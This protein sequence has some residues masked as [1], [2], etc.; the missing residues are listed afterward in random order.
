MSASPERARPMWSLFV[1]GA[2]GAA[3]ALVGLTLLTG[4]R[5]DDAQA[6]P[7][8]ALDARP[9]PPDDPA[10]RAW[11]EAAL[12]RAGV[13]AS[14]RRA[15]RFPLRGAGRAPNETFPLLSFGCPDTAPCGPL[16]DALAPELAGAGLALTRSIGGDRPGR[17]LYRAVSAAG[18]PLLALRAFPP[19]P[20]LVVIVSGLGQDAR[21]ADALLRLDEHVTLALRAD[22]PAGT[23]L[24]A[25]L[26]AR[27]REVL[28]ELPLAADATAPHALSAQ[29]TP[30]AL[31][32]QTEALLDRLPGAVG[33]TL[34][35]DDRLLASAAH[36]GAVLQPVGGRGLFVVDA[37]ASPTSVSEATA[38]VLGVRRVGRTHTL[39]ASTSLKA[40]EA[41]LALDGQ[42]TVV[43]PADAAG[44]D[45][46]GAWLGELALRGVRPYRASETAL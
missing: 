25:R 19:G 29:R 21:A 9:P 18:A 2:V 43:V 12:S 32:S 44:L 38:V 30:E 4:P 39:D 14:G 16:L 27:G 41:A 37:P 13:L 46:L 34:T 28:V 10:A 26:A 36:I 40:V 24:A 20:R 3:A 22:A 45:A 7:P 11:V 17:P 15:G 6:P 1:A 31:R 33:V 8:S 23:E 5:L 35:R 42:A